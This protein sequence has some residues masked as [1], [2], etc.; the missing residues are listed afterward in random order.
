MYLTAFNLTYETKIIPHYLPA[1]LEDP[2]RNVMV[3]VPS[4]EMNCSR[5]RR[6]YFI[7]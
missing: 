3:G 2:P 5:P 1:P 7:I 6:W 4:N